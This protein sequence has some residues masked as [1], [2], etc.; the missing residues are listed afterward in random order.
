MFYRALT[1]GIVAFWLLMMG[2]L[3]RV[4]LSSGEG[5]LM[6]VPVDYVW[7]LMFLREQPSDLVL[8]SQ[9][10]R[11][12]NFHLQPRRLPTG[13]DG[14]PGPVRV[15]NGSG[16]LALSLPG[17]SGQNLTLRGSLEMDER[18]TARRV[19][20]NVSLHTPGQAALGTTL[21][22]DGRPAR[23]DW[24]YQVRQADTV[25]REDSGSAASLLGALDFGSWG[26]D[27]RALL[28][29]EQ[30][31]V[32]TAKPTARRGVL[33]TDA[34]DVEAFIVT[35]HRGEPLETTVYVSQLGQILAIKTFGGYDLYDD[36]LAP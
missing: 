1:V 14:A 35:I 9:R 31:Q 19:G 11:I 18:N 13:T 8:Y 10:Q 20:L 32:D 3:L 21:T 6:P 28:Q 2:M 29:T 30:A 25:S 33:H 22:L 16:G 24:H 34:E 26:F 12:G 27:P 17:L 23:D 36:A 5:E 15:L 4:E 7:R